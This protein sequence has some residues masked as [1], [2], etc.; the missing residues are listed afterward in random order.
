M[1]KQRKLFANETQQ[2]KY[3]PGHGKVERL[4]EGM[5]NDA[6]TTATTMMRTENA[7]PQREV[8]K[9]TAAST[10]LAGIGRGVGVK[11]KPEKRVAAASQVVEGEGGDRPNPDANFFT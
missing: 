1:P 7:K 8:K 10:S 11:K 9:Y 6:S 2:K 3:A 4:K 5:W